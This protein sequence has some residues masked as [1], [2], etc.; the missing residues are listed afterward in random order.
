MSSI[1]APVPIIQ[2]I[3]TDASLH[4][5]VCP[6]SVTRATPNARAAVGRVTFTEAD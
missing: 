2:H 1:I 4:L 6:T 3:A 5:L